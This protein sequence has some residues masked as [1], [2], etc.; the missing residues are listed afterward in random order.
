LGQEI[1]ETGFLQLLL[2]LTER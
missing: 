2:L 1:Q